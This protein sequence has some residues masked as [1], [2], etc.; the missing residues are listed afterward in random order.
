MEER[1][2]KGV[3]DGMGRRGGD[4]NGEGEGEAGE[5]QEETNPEHG[6]NLHRRHLQQHHNHNQVQGQPHQ[7]H[8]GGS[9]LLGDVLALQR[10]RQ[11][12]VNAT[13][14]LKHEEREKTGGR[15]SGNGRHEQGDGA[16][17]VN[18]A[19]EGLNRGELGEVPKD[20]RPN[21]HGH[22]EAG[23]DPPKREVSVRTRGPTLERGGPDE[24]EGV[25]GTLK[26]R[27]NQADGQNFDVTGGGG[28]SR[29]QTGQQ[30]LVLS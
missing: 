19:G 1:A 16:N 29:A 24:D 12:P 13:H 28:N 22:H 18:W 6:R 9:G 27:L 17:Q 8:H 10:S 2:P 14:G 21:H 5:D 26:E 4:N 11:G 25:H 3:L 20:H 15:V 7:V 23:K 30:R